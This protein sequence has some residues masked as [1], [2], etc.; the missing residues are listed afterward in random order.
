M[1]QCGDLLA[2]YL[3][4]K[5]RGKV[6]PCVEALYKVGVLSPDGPDGLAKKFFRERHIL[7][8]APD[9]TAGHIDKLTV[10]C[11]IIKAL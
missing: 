7:K 6:I 3:K 4:S 10:I 5:L 8:L 9:D 1:F 11:F 2:S